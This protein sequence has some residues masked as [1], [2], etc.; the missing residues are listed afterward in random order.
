MTKSHGQ[1]SKIKLLELVKRTGWKKWGEPRSKPGNDSIY[2]CYRRGNAYIWVG[3][4]YLEA[5][6]I[7]HAIPY[8]EPEAGREVVSILK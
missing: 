6:W 7:G 5:N 3:N 1:L 2:Q 4:Y 8:A